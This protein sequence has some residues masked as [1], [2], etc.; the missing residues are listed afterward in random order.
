MHA[1]PLIQRGGDG[2]PCLFLAASWARPAAVEEPAGSVS[3]RRGVHDVSRAEAQRPSASCGCVRRHCESDATA[4][5]R[6]RRPRLTDSLSQKRQQ[7]A[8]DLLWRLPLE[9]VSVRA[10][11]LR[12]GLGEYWPSD[13]LQRARTHGCSRPHPSGAKQKAAPGRFYTHCYRRL[14]TGTRRLPTSATGHHAPPHATGV[15]RDQA[16]ASA[17][18]A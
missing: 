6:G 13:V 12:S 8:I 14:G 2:Y 17:A 16:A 11:M 3:P 10:Q 7:F 9:K 4:Q 18:E 15:T 5:G 1:V